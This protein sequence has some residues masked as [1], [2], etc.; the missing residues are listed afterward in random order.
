MSEEKGHY[1]TFKKDDTLSLVARRKGYKRWQDI[2]NHEKNKDIRE[3]YPNSGQLPVGLKIWLPG[4]EKGSAVVKKSAKYQHDVDQGRY[5]DGFDFGIF[6]CVSEKEYY[7]LEQKDFESYIKECDSLESVAD[8]LRVAQTAPIQED[9]SEEKMNIAIEEKEKDIQQKKDK[10]VKLLKSSDG[11]PDFTELICLNKMIK[12]GKPYCKGWRRVRRSWRNK[13]YMRKMP[14]KEI[15]NKIKEAFS[16]EKKKSNKSLNK[17]FADKLI[18]TIKSELFNKELV[19]G[20]GF[21]PIPEEWCFKGAEYKS[22]KDSFKDHKHFDGS[23]EAAFLRYQFGA[24]ISSEVNLSEGVMNFGVNGQAR[25]ALAEGKVEGSLSIPSKKGLSL[26]SLLPEKTRKA[27]V[28][29]PDRE[30][31]IK[32]IIKA[33]LSGFVGASAA[34]SL[35]YVDVKCKGKEK[36]AEVGIKGEAFAGASG[37]AELA[38]ALEWKPG[39][40]ISKG[41][42]IDWESIIK[43]GLKASFSAGIGGKFDMSFKI[44]KD[45]KVQFIVKAGAVVGLGGSADIVSEFNFKEG[46]DFMWYVADSVDYHK[47]YDAL[48]DTYKIFSIAKLI[49]LIHPG[50][51]GIIVINEVKDL[52]K[53]YIPE[54]WKFWDVDNKVIKE[55]ERGKLKGNILQEVS[56]SQLKRCSPETLAFAMRL[57]MQTVEKGD[58]DIILKILLNA[59]QHHEYSDKF[60]KGEK[61]HKLRWTIRNLMGFEA[62]RQDKKGSLEK[63]KE[64]LIDFFKIREH[65]KEEKHKNLMEYLEIAK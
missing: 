22:D 30:V 29:K 1:Y 14:S 47:A 54:D 36:K 45:R 59:Q 21:L 44:T 31:F 38:G 11:K 9:L 43:A 42:E 26:F 6:Y 65:F 8:A 28:I 19:S 37:S 32:F 51:Q 50:T 41:E 23:V 52:I 53:E 48:E 4:L 56:A 7:L 49:M 35:P 64:R 16:K 61:Y 24:D 34:L 17:R 55:L 13:G 25:F 33:E 3:K 40:N 12:I 63:G 10:L 20:E 62:A 46:F 27:G 60:T 57:I 2:W 58:Q 18:P 39:E 15:E 5:A